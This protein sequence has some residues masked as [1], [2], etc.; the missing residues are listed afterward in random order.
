MGEPNEG[1]LV[2]DGAMEDGP[3][4]LPANAACGRC[5]YSRLV[6]VPGQL[7]RVRICKRFPPVP[8]LIPSQG[9]GGRPVLNITVQAPAVADTDFCYEFDESD[10]ASLV[11]TSLGLG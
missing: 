3:I 9:P 5:I 8:V 10:T 1:A 7:V 4:D 11:P 2:D 6:E